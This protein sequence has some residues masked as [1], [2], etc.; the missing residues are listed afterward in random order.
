MSR[1]HSYRNRSLLAL[2][3][4]E[5]CAPHVAVANQPSSPAAPVTPAQVTQTEEWIHVPTT[6]RPPIQNYPHAGVVG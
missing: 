2:M 1:H 3:A 6:E 5:I 4:L